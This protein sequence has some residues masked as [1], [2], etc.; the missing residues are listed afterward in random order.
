[1]NIFVEDD[2]ILKKIQTVSMTILHDKEIKNKE[3]FIL[4]NII[5]IYINVS[6]IFAFL[7]INLQ[8]FEN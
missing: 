3:F 7:K 5:L 8:I 2:S 6:K 4:Y 1:M